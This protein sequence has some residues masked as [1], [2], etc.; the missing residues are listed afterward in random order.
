LIYIAKKSKPGVVMP[1]NLSY[2]GGRDRRQLARP[3]SR[4]YLKNKN[5]NKGPGH[6]AQVLLA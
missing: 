2:L 1:V 4:P 3:Y 6:E 5:T